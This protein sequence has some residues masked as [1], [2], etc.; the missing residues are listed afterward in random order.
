MVSSRRRRKA[1]AA[2]KRSNMVGLSGDAKLWLAI[3]YLVC[4]SRGIVS[5]LEIEEGHQDPG[6]RRA[7]LEL[8]G[9]AGT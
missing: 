6:I 3:G 7:A 4:D 9:E 5:D 1:L 2:L 8:L